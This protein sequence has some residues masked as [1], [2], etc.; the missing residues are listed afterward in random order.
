ML[1]PRTPPPTPNFCAAI[2]A[3]LRLRPKTEGQSSCRMH[4]R[5]FDTGLSVEG[6]KAEVV[7]DDRAADIDGLLP[8]GRRMKR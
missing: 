6:D 5:A 4:Y 2:R 7:D 8:D 3:R 1:R